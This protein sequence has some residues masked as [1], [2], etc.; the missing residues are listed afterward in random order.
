[1]Y[2][3]TIPI[4]VAGLGLRLPQR[5]PSLA[6]GLSYVVLVLR[7]AAVG[8]AVLLQTLQFAGSSVVAVYL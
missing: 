5:L 1:M 7:L 6:A 2:R 3:Q 8:S 4:A